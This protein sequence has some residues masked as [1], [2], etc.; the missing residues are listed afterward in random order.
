MGW[1]K[2]TAKK[3]SCEYSGKMYQIG[4]CFKSLSHLLSS[5]QKLK[6]YFQKWRQEGL[7]SVELKAKSTEVLRL[8]QNFP[9]YADILLR[10]TCFIV[11]KLP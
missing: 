5:S 1:E 9:V 6:E 4:P 10:M 3:F 11:Y 7:E 2:V 8:S